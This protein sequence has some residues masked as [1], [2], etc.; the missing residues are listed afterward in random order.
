MKILIASSIDPA[1]IEQLESK[2]QVTFIPGAS[3]HEL[4]AAIAGQDCL[5]FRSGVQISRTVL[6]AADSLKLILRAGSGVDNI[7]L[8]YVEKRTIPF[9]RIPGPGAQAVAEMSFAMMLALSRNLFAA[10]RAWRAGNWVKQEMTGYSL[11]GKVLGI[12]GAGNIGKQVGAMGAA[13][14][15][16]VIGCVEDPDCKERF[17]LAS[18]GIDLVDLDTVLTSADYISVHVPLT[19]KTRN[20]IDASALAKVRPQAIL[21]NLARGGVVDE[22]ALR[23]ALVEGRLRGAGMDVHAAEGDGM[24]SPLADL[25]NVILTPHIGANSFDAQQEIG[26]IIVDSVESFVKEQHKVA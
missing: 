8:A 21:I 22:Q 19:D 13:W 11:K 9:I 2:H 25:A 4:I 7:D 5:V 1:A 24:I 10:D 6:E 12:I 15:M 26:C 16:N 17:D 20:L 3:E 18:C 23:D 14:G